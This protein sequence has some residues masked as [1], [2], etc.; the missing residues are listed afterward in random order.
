MTSV[1]LPFTIGNDICR[2]ARVRLILKG[3][4]GPRFIHR[5]LKPEEIKNPTTA[6]I[7]RCILDHDAEKFKRA[8]PPRMLTFKKVVLDAPSFTRAVEFIAGRFAAKE[9]VMKA[10]PH[11]RLTFQRIA[12]VRAGF[13]EPSRSE[14]SILNQYENQIIPIRVT[15]TAYGEAEEAEPTEKAEPLP[16]GPLMAKI[17]MVVGQPTYASVS[18]SHDG[19]YA[20]AVCVVSNLPAHSVSRPVIE[21]K[22][23]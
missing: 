5:I 19:D 21:K 2:I 13:S 1:L 4:L 23:L 9:A 16:S 14:N 17:T 22:F 15:P 3:N 11:D 6:K 12:I 20:T 7:L 8:V 10:Y 18:I